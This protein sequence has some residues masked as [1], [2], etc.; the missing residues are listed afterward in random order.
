[1]AKTPSDLCKSNQ[2]SA[3]VH[4]Y[5]LTGGSGGVYGADCTTEGCKD[6]LNFG[7]GVVA[8]APRIVKAAIAR[9]EATRG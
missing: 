6:H 3:H 5:A 8:G 7:D 4:T 9:W 2:S 1:M